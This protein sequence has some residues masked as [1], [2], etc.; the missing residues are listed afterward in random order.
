MKNITDIVSKDKV[1]G[2]E[3]ASQQDMDNRE[4]LDKSF[5]IALLILSR[6]KEL[7]WTQLR[8]AEEMKVSPQYVNKI[9]KGRENLTLETI[10]LLENVLGTS[11]I[12]ISPPQQASI[13]VR[14][15]SVAHQISHTIYT[16][17]NVVKP[18]EER[19]IYIDEIL[20]PYKFEE[21]A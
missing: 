17:I 12:N 6:L 1:S 9:V 11:L 15:L 3:T 20:P 4:W 18:A 19:N 21:A 2:F 16:P 8:L 10:T 5:E 7:K 13:T 14:I